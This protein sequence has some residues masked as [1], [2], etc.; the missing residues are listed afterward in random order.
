MA[1]KQK[2]IPKEEAYEVFVQAFRIAKV[3]TE[4]TVELGKQLQK[5]KRGGYKVLA[6]CLATTYKLDL[7]K[8]PFDNYEGYLRGRFNAIKKLLQNRHEA[9]FGFDKERFQHVI[10]YVKRIKGKALAIEF[11]YTVMY[12]PKTFSVFNLWRRPVFG[13]LIKYDSHFLF[14]SDEVNFSFA[15]SPLL[16]PT[17]MPP[18]KGDWLKIKT[19]DQVFYLAVS[20]GNGKQLS[21]NA[22]RSFFKIRPLRQAQ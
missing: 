9:S 21:I 22:I 17:T 1:D 4:D 3:E 10:N 18:F 7:E 13:R 2:Q 12:T 15:A 16:T 14:Q 11:D 6:E 5:P 19:V 8:P 20:D